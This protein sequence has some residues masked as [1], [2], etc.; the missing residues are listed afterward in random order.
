[1][2]RPNP[3]SKAFRKGFLDGFTAYYHFLDRQTYPRAKSIDSS[4]AGAWQAVGDA[5]RAAEKTEW[6]VSGKTARQVARENIA[7]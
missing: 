7:A 6:G 3:Q 4:V 2:P 1:M 5:M